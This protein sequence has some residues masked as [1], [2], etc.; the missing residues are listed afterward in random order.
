M[1]YEIIRTSQFKKDYK[2]SKKRG[3]DLK[4]LYAVI[5]MLA[6]GQ[7]LP[8]QN[9]DHQLSGGYVGY[10]ECHIQPDWLLI[11]KITD[12]ELILTLTRTGTHSELF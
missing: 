5:E 7:K 10:R 6:K 4:L 9:K 8:E 1:K 3:K 2:L 12:K 11:Y